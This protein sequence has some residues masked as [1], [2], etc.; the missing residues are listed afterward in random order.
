MKL[1]SPGIVLILL[2]VAGFTLSASAKTIYV[3]PNGNDRWSGRSSTVS[4]GNNDGPLATIKA[5]LETART[6]RQQAGQSNEPFE[7]VLRGGVYELTEPIELT[8]VDSGSAPDKPFVIS[9]FDG[10]SPIISGGRR[11]SGW[12]PVREMPGLWQTKIEDVALGKWFFRQL[13]IDGLRKQRARTPNNGY[14]RIQGPSPQDKPVKIK[15]RPGDIKSEWA[16]GDV[17][18]IALLAWADIRMQIR[19]VDQSS[20]TATLSGNPRPSN[21]ENQ[22]RYYI[23]NAPDALDAPGEWFLDRKTGV[24]T[25][26]P[27]PGQN[28]HKAEVIAPRLEELIWMHGDL[29]KKIPVSNVVLR[30]LTFRHTDWTLGDQ[31]YADTQAAVATPGDIRAEASVDCR[32]EN[33]LFEHLAGYAVELGRGCQRVTISGNR[34]FDLGA[35]GVRIGE[36]GVRQDAFELNHSHQ[37][38]DNEMYQ[39]G[40]VYPPAVGVFILQSG[41]NRVA[42]NHIHDLYYTAISVGW[43]WGYRETPCRDNIVEFNHLHHIGQ[44]LLSDMG[45]VYTLGIQKGTVI[46]NNLIHDVESFTYGGW[47]L[48]PDEG[49]SEIVWENNVVYRTKSAGFHQH[50]GRENVVRNNIFAFGREY[51]LMRTRTEPHI[52]FIFQ[53]NIV[54]FDSGKLLGSNWTNDKFTMSRNLY[55]DARDPS[56]NSSLLFAGVLISDWRARGHDAE[57]IIAD[58]LFIDPKNGDF[59]LQANSPAFKLGFKPIDLS[60]VGVRSSK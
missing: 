24:L 3:A 34:M 55:F 49:S 43:T 12:E 7:I 9:A 50:Y 53:N 52:S 18:V 10:E 29:E 6:Q 28:M 35:G 56:G 11:I 60:S 5:A 51:Q 26:W 31:G 2:S 36:P 37:I 4:P 57:S 1:S 17:E 41:Q 27:E 30:G 21:K 54:Y 22:A 32:I 25:Y 39:L 59:Q 48:Y 13:F 14:F 40:R 58:P 8:A 47:G 19:D 23:E 46:R 20:H 38:I 45:A 33:C 44:A 15:F 16:G 42:H